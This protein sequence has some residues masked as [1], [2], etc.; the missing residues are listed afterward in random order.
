MVWING[1]ERGTTPCS[2]KVPRGTATVT[3]VMAG[4]LS[5]TST[6][7]AVDGKSVAQ[8]LQA[9]EPPLTGE[10]RF[11]AE[12]KTTGKLPIVVDGRE[13]GILCPYSKLRVDPGAHSIG[14]LVPA[15]GK[16]HAKELTL[17]AGVRSIMFGD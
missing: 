6:F 5:S 2:V 17:S 15:T 16:V 14:V 1:D 4:H 11:R 9:V 7:E 3:L 8:T 12:C 13:T 10:A